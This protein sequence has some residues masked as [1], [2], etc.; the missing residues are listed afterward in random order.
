VDTQ[1]IG[2]GLRGNITGG[3]FYNSFFTLT[4]GR[5]L[6]YLKEEGAVSGAYEYT[7]VLS[8]AGGLGLDF[9]LPQVLSSA[10]GLDFVLSTGDT[11]DDRASFY[12]DSIS[13]SPSLFIPVTAKPL[14]VVLAPTLG[15]IMVV[16]ASYSLKP[17]SFMEGS[18]FADNV[19]TAIKFGVIARHKSG[20][21][22]VSVPNTDSDKNYLG[23]E[24]DISVSFRPF[25]DLGVSLTGGV[26]LPNAS[27]G[28][29]YDAPN[30]SGAVTKAEISA[31]FSF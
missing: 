17:L 10:A 30:A 11:W 2:F 31:S 14:T 9:Y 24:V 22:S 15:N 13:E 3:L 20:P 16:G 5:T 19:Q 4:T 25:S 27:D 21:V 6:S 29:P 7:P 18:V 23:S 12:E 1:Y 28:G 26:F 8:G